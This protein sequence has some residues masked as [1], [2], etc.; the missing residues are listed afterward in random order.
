[1]DFHK[2]V[3][4][5]TINRYKEDLMMFLKLRLAVVERYSDTVDYKQ[6]EGQIQK[7][8]D[9]HI[10][11]EKVEVI[12]ELVNIFD[13]EKFQQEVENTAGKAAKAD[14]IA[15]RTA[16]HI[17]EKFSQMLKETIADYEAK[18]INEAQYL[19]KVKEIMESVLSHTDNDI[20]EPLRDKDIAKAFYG[21]TFESLSEKVQDNVVKTQIAI[22]TALHIDVLIKEAVL[23]NNQPII[24][25]QYKTNITGKLLIEIGDY[26]IDEV[27][28]KY[29]IDLA[30]IEMDEIAT[31]CIEVAK[32][33]YKV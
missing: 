10:T 22:Q 6:Y 19:S 21:L 28:D 20:P 27:R 9:T 13:K 26:L 25:W 32:L 23:D 16:K 5:K 7:L 11:T 3:E 1:M 18:R 33:R 15:S 31:K 2:Q 24:D 12:T 14:K 4:E 30:F 29:N 8:I 17:S